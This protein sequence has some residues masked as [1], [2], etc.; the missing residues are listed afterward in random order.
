MSGMWIVLLAVACDGSSSTP[1]PPTPAASAVE[2]RTPPTSLKA[3]RLGSAFL[4]ACWFTSYTDEQVAQIG[5]LAKTSAAAES[6][7]ATAVAGKLLDVTQFV[8]DGTTDAAAQKAAADALAASER[9]AAELS[10]SHLVSLV[11]VMGPEQLAAG[12]SQSG[13]SSIAAALTTDRWLEENNPFSH[14][15][16]D[17]SEAGGG[18]AI[19][20]AKLSSA[21][22]YLTLQGAI[23]AE[24]GTLASLDLA[25]PDWK[26]TATT[27]G[28]RVFDAFESH[29][30]ASIAAYAAWASALPEADRVALVLADGT[31]AALK[32][33]SAAAGSDGGL[34]AGGQGS[35]MEGGGC[36]VAGFGGWPGSTV[37]RV[38]AVSSTS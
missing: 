27:S 20:S 37:R 16:P 29:R 25:A 36:R 8:A 7:A 18:A 12:G 5:V 23:S 28:K 15:P 10:F 13:G 31:K 24:T 11:A 26:E 22:S 34:A 6:A 17:V 19:V 30:A 38:L 35:G 4:H 21:R 33:P 1:A 2:A 9:A 3:V 14:V 32:L